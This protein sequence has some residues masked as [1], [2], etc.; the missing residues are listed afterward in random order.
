MRSTAGVGVLNIGHR[1]ARAYAPENTIEAFQKAVDLGCDMIELDLHLTRDGALVVHH[2]DD[3]LRCTDIAARHP[4]AGSYFVSDWTLEQISTLDAGSWF[5][6]ELGIAPAQRQ[7]F[8]RSLTA[9]EQATF[10]SDGDRQRHASGKVRVPSLQAVFEWIEAT[11]LLVNVEI[12]S[13]PRRYE[14]I[15][16]RLL[17]CIARFGL[18]GRTLV[19]S[20]DHQQLLAVRAGND[21][22]ATAVLTSDRIATPEAY[23]RMLDADAYHPCCHGDC[24]SVGFGSVSGAV[25]ATLSASIAGGLH[26]NAW[27]CNGA[28]QMRALLAAG[29]SGIVTDYPNRLTEVLRESGVGAA[30]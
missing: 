27:T 15:A 3:L 6:R 18:E 23:L 30:T 29:V 16:A 25:D 11:N 4:D 12:K 26:V 5:A 10:I 7:A 14:G 9:D 13:L 1:G 20:F 8:L 19:S 21:R 22:I 2:D 17:D 28:P 24:D